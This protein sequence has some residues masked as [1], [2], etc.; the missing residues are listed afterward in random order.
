M[1]QATVLGVVTSLCLLASARADIRVPPEKKEP[2][3]ITSKVTIKHGAIKGVDRNVV[4]K[5]I[6][7]ANLVHGV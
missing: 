1:R 2:V 5:V 4:A 7:P 6:L 3:R